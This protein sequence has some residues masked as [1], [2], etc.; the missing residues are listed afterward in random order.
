LSLSLEEQFY[1]IWPSLFALLPRKVSPR[2]AV[3][4]ALSGP[5][6]RTLNYFLFPSFRGFAPDGFESHVDLLMAGCASAFFLD[7]AAWRKRIRQIPVW[8]TLAATSTFLVIVDPLLANHFPE[9]S[10]PFVIANLIIPTMEAT[11]IALALMAVVEGKQG[12]S[13]R[14]LNSRIPIHIGK[15]SYS[16]YIWQQL[17]L[18]PHDSLNMFSMLGRLL[19][20]Y[21]AGFCSFNFLE[22]PFLGL[23]SKFRYG[24]SV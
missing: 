3:V 10:A 9:H 19:A 15:L 12:L 17:I 8:P 5:I 11:A 21:L 6:L 18:V 23:R 4:L 13:F 7:S 22:R 20:V 16:I 1:L 24:V 2:L 14:V